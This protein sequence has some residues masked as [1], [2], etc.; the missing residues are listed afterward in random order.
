[1]RIDI[2]IAANKNQDQHWW[3]SLMPELIRADRE[4]GITIGQVIVFGGALPDYT[5]NRIARQY[6]S[7]STTAENRTAVA[8]EHLEGESE[9]IFWVDDDTVPPPGTIERLIALDVDIAGGVYYLRRPPYNPVCYRRM[10]NG[11]YAALFDFQVGEILEVDSVGMGCTLVRRSVYERIR[12][13]HVL[14]RRMSGTLMPIHKEDLV[15]SRFLAKQIKR[16]A[17]EVIM[18]QG[19]IVQLQKLQPL[20]EEP[21]AWPFYA[22]EFQRTEDH[23]FCELAQR[24]GCRIK[25]DTGVECSHWGS[26]PVTGEE[27]RALRWEMEADDASV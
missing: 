26:S 22:M 1:M 12:D 17:G 3:A 2:G 19:Q 4:P 5:R 14:L 11:S 25:V 9:A 24:V 13:Q 15:E 18:A 8:A 23:H 7:P 6:F 21:R 20:E 10:P 16:H 27:F